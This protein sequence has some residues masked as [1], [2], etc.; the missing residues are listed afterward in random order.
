MNKAIKNE[1]LHNLEVRKDLKSLFDRFKK[2][3]NNGE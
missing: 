1:I 2:G 3:L